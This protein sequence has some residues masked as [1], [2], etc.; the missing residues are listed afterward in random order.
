[1][2]EDEKKMTE[3]ASDVSAEAA[4]DN[5]ASD[6]EA[7]TAQDDRSNTAS[8]ASS[9]KAAKRRKR[10]ITIG[11]ICAIVVVAGAGFWVWHE[12]PSFCNA[13]C[14][15]PMDP[16]LETYE[17]S[18]GESGVDKW[19][20]FV[21]DMDTLMVVQHKE[22]ADMTCLDCHIPT[23]GEQVSEGVHWVGGTYD[24]PLDERSLTDLN[25]YRHLPNAEEFCMNE[26]CHNTTRDELARLTGGQ[27]YNP[28]VTIAGHRQL[29]CSDC[30]K[31]HRQSVM[32]CTRCHDEANVPEGWLSAEESAGITSANFD[33]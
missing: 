28:H 3:G 22:E 24:Y 11:V 2:S 6:T 20:N 23:I 25:A 15:A 12:Q 10:G 17:G 13:I 9:P 30:H 29:Q 31:A 26:A 4:V 5:V 1:M 18:S 7:S 32:A 21:E 14:H 27:K 19:G 16:Y 8:G 33:F